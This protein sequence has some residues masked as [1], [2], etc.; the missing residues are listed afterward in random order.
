MDERSPR[1]ELDALRRANPVAIDQL[2]THSRDR[3]WARIEEATMADNTPQADPGQ[4]RLARWSI[5]ASGVALTLA[6]VAAATLGG[7]PAGIPGPSAAGG[8]GAAGM[9]IQFTTEMLQERQFAFDGT[10]TTINGDQVTLAVTTA[11]W[12][13]PQA[14]SSVT[15]T[16]G[17]GMTGDAVVLE[18][19]PRLAAGSRYLVS[20]D[21]QFMWACGYTVDWDASTA[22]QWAALA[23]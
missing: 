7:G 17:M 3:I 15:L 2:P 23:P 12:G 8:G 21:D 19:G 10:V 16:A 13:S 11:F 22:A 5:A 20:G 6:V 14:G 4:T 9:C 18:G 1:D